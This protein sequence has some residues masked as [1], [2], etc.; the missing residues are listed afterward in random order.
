MPN[1]DVII[2][3]MYLLTTFQITTFDIKS[4]ND[5]ILVSEFDCLDIVLLLIR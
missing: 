1:F 4:I 5:I 2:I 3:L